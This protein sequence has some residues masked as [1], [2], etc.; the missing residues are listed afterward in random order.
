MNLDLYFNKIKVNTLGK[1]LPCLAMSNKGH[2][3]TS[4][5]N[6][7]FFVQ[8]SARFFS[9]LDLQLLMSV[10]EEGKKAKIKCSLKYSRS[11]VP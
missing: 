7:F 4:Q 1:Y 10:G 6:I 8:L 9:N 3:T 11:D 2:K 5:V